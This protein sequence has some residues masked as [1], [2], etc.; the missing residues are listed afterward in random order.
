MYL[1][2]YNDIERKGADA[3]LFLWFIDFFILPEC[4]LIC[5]TWLPPDISESEQKKEILANRCNYS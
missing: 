5:S 3:L 2:N 4:I 1:Q